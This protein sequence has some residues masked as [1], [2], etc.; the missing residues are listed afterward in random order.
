MSTV[1]AALLGSL[2]L[3][4]PPR[5]GVVA[6]GGDAGAAGELQ[7]A[8]ELR[9][10]TSRKVIV[11]GTAEIATTLS[12]GP[13]NAP[14]AVRPVDPALQKEAAGLLRQATDAYYEDRAAVALDRLA[15]L[16]ALQDRTNAFPVS[17]RVRL[18]LWRTAVFLALKDEAQAESEALAALTLNPDLKVDLNEFRPSVR[19]AIDRVRGR[20]FRTATVVVSGLPPGAQLELDDRPVTAPF[21]ATLGRHR[22]T[23]RAPGRR[24]VVRTFDV[25]SDVSI[26]MTLPVSTD[27]ATESV[28]SALAGSAEL[29][30][31]QRTLTEEII[32]RLK[33]DYLVVARPDGADAR[34]TIVNAKGGALA[35]PAGNASAV[36]AWIEGKVAGEAA[37]GSVGVTTPRPPPT[38]RATP[39]P[40]AVARRPRTG[41]SPGLAIAA[42]GGLLWSSRTRTLSGKDA[43]DF[44]TSFGGAGP[45]VV[46]DASMGSP[47][48]RV[49]AA[50][51]S[52]GMS[53]LDVTMPDGSKEQ[54][55]GGSTTMGR[56]HVGWRQSFGRGE[57]DAAPSVWAG[58][59]G[60]FEQH[61]ATDVADDSGDIGLLTS[62]SRTAVELAAGG[63][64]P[65]GGAMQPALSAGLVVAP[66]STWSE[67]PADTTGKNAAPGLA[68]GWNLG[69]AFQATRKIG[70]S[71]EYGGAMR[72]VAFEGEA[73]P[74]V[75]PALTDATIRES[76][77]FFGATAGYRF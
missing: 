34:A 44:E 46:V 75:D 74:P 43:G 11:A 53:T 13:Q 58:V 18:L 25:Q 32:S 9:L 77:H 68:L 59:G 8:I 56:L 39:P 52:Y 71:V 28:L 10:G 50:F 69:V 26:P 6:V 64:Y 57:P 42:S 14:G 66:V 37:G 76:F 62:Y 15:A 16:A 30:R 24:E 47:F 45:R 21:R 41:S 7:R 22:L 33:L 3:A 61:G 20:G 55:T 29:T 12:P 36:A 38:A 65:F 40:G 67:S 31:E 60:S 27:A 35:A 63:R 70:V 73:A 49:E 48:A 19:D 51:L 17:E 5:V 72:S 4:A 23:A 54:V 1:S 2:L